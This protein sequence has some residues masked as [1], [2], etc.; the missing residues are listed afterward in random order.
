MLRV[1]SGLVALVL[2]PSVAQAIEI[3]AADRAAAFKAAGFQPHG[4]QYIRCED[5]AAS[6]MPGS[7]E[8]ADLNGDGLPEAWVKESST[9]C[10]GNTAEAFVLV[11]KDAKGAWAVLLDQV[12]VPV[13]YEDRHLGWPDIEVGG[14]GFDKFPVYRFDGK[15]YVLA[16]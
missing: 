3:S 15:T 8:V 6:A 1:M 13:E 7:I 14:P 2:L 5:T 11:T 10:Y 16:E 9:F 12:G 4:D